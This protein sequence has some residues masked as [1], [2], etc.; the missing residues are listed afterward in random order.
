VIGKESGNWPYNSDSQREGYSATY[1]M[2]QCT[3]EI[4]TVS[5]SEE[6]EM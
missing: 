1:A 2:P 3:P 4:E 5:T 6:I